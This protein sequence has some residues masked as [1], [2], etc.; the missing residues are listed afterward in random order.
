MGYQKKKS[1]KYMT[2]DCFVHAYISNKTFLSG[3]APSKQ[4]TDLEQLIQSKL[5]VSKWGLLSRKQK[6]IH[7]T[8]PTYAK[9]AG[10]RQTLCCQPVNPT[11]QTQNSNL[12][13][14]T[15]TPNPIPQNPNS[16]PQTLSS[17]PQT[18]NP[19]LQNLYSKLAA[20]TAKGKSQTPYCQPGV[21]TPL[22]S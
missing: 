14:Q 22:P 19:K 5:L 13:L 2:A 10:K 4:V 21:L 9:S 20:N 15:Q 17:K 18:P 1:G 7:R 6:P 16:K 12:K 8:S 3:I 11:P